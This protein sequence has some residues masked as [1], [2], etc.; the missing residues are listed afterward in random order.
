MA[1]RF[2]ARSTT[3]GEIRLTDAAIALLQEGTAEAD[4][5]AEADVR[6]GVTFGDSTY[7]GTLDLPAESD[8]RLNVDYDNET[9]RGSYVAPDA[10]VGMFGVRRK[11]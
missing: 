1:Y 4:Y 5:P 3:P 9:K 11:A 6:D 2:K 7:T 8:V 10:T